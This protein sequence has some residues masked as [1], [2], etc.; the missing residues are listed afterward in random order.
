[1]MHKGKSVFVIGLIIAFF[2]VFYA[3]VGFETY[4]KNDI[5]KGKESADSKLTTYEAVGCDSITIAKAMGYD[6]IVS[7]N[8]R[9]T[10][11]WNEFRKRLAR[12]RKYA[13]KPYQVIDTTQ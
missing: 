13:E 10:A 4:R 6:S 12:P 5:Q 3:V 8:A 7:E 2:S 1:M 9:I 11:N